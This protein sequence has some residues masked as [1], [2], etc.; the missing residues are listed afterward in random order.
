MRTHVVMVPGFG[1]FDVRSGRST[2][3][4]GVTELFRRWRGA[5]GRE[6]ACLHYFDNLPTAAVPTRARKLER[7]LA[8]LV[9][10]ELVQGGDELVLVGHSTG[11][12][13][14]RQLVR[15]LDGRD[16]HHLL[17]RIRRLVFMSTPQLGTNVADWVRAHDR[18]AHVVVSA[19]RR[20]VGLPLAPIEWMLAP[21]VRLLPLDR[22]LARLAP[23]HAQL[24]DAVEDARRDM[25]PGRGPTDD[26][27]ADADARA[28][29]SEIEL[30]LENVD[31]DFFAIDDLS[32]VRPPQL[33]RERVV[34]SPAIDAA[35]WRRRGIA[36]QS[37]ATIGNPVTPT[38]AVREL[39][40]LAEVLAAAHA[41][42]A[43][44]DPVYRIVHTACAGGLPAAR[45]RA[46]PWLPG[47]GRDGVYEPRPWE[48]DGIV[49]TA[50]ATAFA[51]TT[52][53]C[54]L[55]PGDHG[56]I[57]GH[58]EERDRSSDTRPASQ[59][60]RDA[61]DLL[62]SDRPGS[63]APVFPR[64][65]ESASSTSPCLARISTWIRAVPAHRVSQT[66]GSRN[67]G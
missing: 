41:D 59:R 62:G 7:F 17:P 52:A 44:T 54:F 13:D 8:Q 57:I 22:M 30:W 34:D 63:F 38:D 58:Y 9:D 18:S 26:P 19:F 67:Q 10:R 12:L 33:A 48:H 2:Y 40:S 25:E 24:L 37:Y 3:Y 1:G 42:V 56:D 60:E 50:S 55:V 28:A 39:A 35:I 32:V 36:T 53:R 45:G 4:T 11:G 21:V 64:V 5:R 6:R 61:Y 14:L 27:L 20:S 46:V 47:C 51:P 23:G 49:N 15:D 31:D 66:P 16:G 29:R 65:W 43:N